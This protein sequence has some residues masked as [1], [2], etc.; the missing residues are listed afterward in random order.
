MTDPTPLPTTNVVA[1]AIDS[2]VAVGES[3]AVT[4]VEKA[5][6]TSEPLLAVP[7]IKECFEAFVSWFMGFWSK[8]GQLEVTK[9]VTTVQTGI[10]ETSLE[11]A[12][13]AVEAA[14]ASGDQ[15]AIATAEAA[16][17]KAQS[18]AANNDGSAQPQ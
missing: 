12:N 3:A 11:S 16:F 18:A 5:A 1:S 4:V 7:F 2:A 10:E 13:K 17:Q 9:V 14:I 15:N 8:T 6:E